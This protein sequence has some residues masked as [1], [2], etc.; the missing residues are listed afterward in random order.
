MTIEYMGGAPVMPDNNSNIHTKS[1]EV[2]LPQAII[3]EFA[4]FL[5]PQ[6]RKFYESEQGRQEFEKWQTK[7]EE[8]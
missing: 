7:Q 6:I 5:V 2:E 1:S 3:N 8:S 4:R